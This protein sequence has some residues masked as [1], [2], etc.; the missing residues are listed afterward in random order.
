MDGE[1]HR[2]HSS[3]AGLALAVNA[4]HFSTSTVR[5][6]SRELELP[7]GLAVKK[8]VLAASHNIAFAVLAGVITLFC[9]S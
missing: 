2:P 7:D 4:N 8:L 5:Q 3:A 9:V 6:L 1:T